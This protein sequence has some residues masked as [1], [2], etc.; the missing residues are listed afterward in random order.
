MYIISLI[1]LLVSCTPLFA[2]NW[3]QGGTYDV[4]STPAFSSNGQYIAFQHSEFQAQS[5]YLSVF[6]ITTGQQFLLDS[7]KES[8]EWSSTRLLFS[9]D[10][11]TLFA[12]RSNGTIEAYT[13]ENGTKKTLLT[14]SLHHIT[15]L[16]MLDDTVLVL[17]ENGYSYVAM[18]RWN[19]QTGIREFA[20]T[21]SLSK[22]EH[23][24]ILSDN[25][26]TLAL[27]STSRKDTVEFRSTQDG[28][29]RS[30]STLPNAGGYIAS[31]VLADDGLLA[32]V[33]FSSGKIAVYHTQSGLLFRVLQQTDSWYSTGSFIDNEHLL[34]T[35]MEPNGEKLERRNIITDTIEQVITLPYNSNIL[36]ISPSTP[37]VALGI[38]GIQGCTGEMPAGSIT[39][40]VFDWSA[41]TLQQMFPDGHTIV[42]YSELPVPSVSFSRGDTTL[43]VSSL[44]ENRT[45]VRRVADG[46]VLARISFGGIAVFAPGDTTLLLA[47]GSILQQWNIG[48]GQPVATYDITKDT[49]RAMYTSLYHSLIAIV[50]DTTV[51]LWDYTNQIVKYSWSTNSHHIV[52][53]RF[54]E[55]GNR[56]LV[57]TDDLHYFAWDAQTGTQVSHTTIT[58][59]GNSTEAQSLSPDG[60]L[61]AIKEH[62]T[63]VIRSLPSGDSIRTFFYN[64]PY[65][66]NSFG[67]TNCG[68]LLISTAITYEP[69]SGG[70]IRLT[71]ARTGT[72][73]CV[74]QG[75]EE[76]VVLGISP[77]CSHIYTSECRGILSCINVCDL[78]V[79]VQHH[80][81]QDN[82]APTIFPNPSSGGCSLRCAF[83]TPQNVEITIFTALGVRMYQPVQ[84]ALPAGEYDLPLQLQGLASGL[85]FVRIQTDMGIE[86]LPLFVQK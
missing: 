76:T 13:P 29:L 35:R 33:L 25:G 50:M 71:N 37:L 84:Y 82:P 65:Q 61:V 66:I 10:G 54:D 27:W 39:I 64:P 7:S 57:G 2:N 17:V 6:I 21:L 51:L 44:S 34:L 49:I 79:S 45:V 32:A 5:L 36:T 12:A 74:M 15:S 80:P 46:T 38:H 30:V 8:T 60:T 22:T 28:S 69:I 16:A 9:R 72:D 31:V 11:T 77:R 1:L 58:N 52:A 26:E 68:Q 78:P 67:F 43:V 4:V 48:Q 70:S 40:G 83:L 18:E 73:E 85:Y 56:F 81:Q 20:T 53:A 41:P 62:S 63:I 75:T 24:A 55:W 59:S 19:I 86:L 14:S 47:H 3:T 23:K 42:Q